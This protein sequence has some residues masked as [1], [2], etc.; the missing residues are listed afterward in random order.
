[1]VRVSKLGTVMD[2]DVLKAM[3]GPGWAAIPLF[4]TRHR[5]DN[6]P[7]ILADI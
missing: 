6:Q 3:A 4:V 7:Y 5:E 2:V 1:M